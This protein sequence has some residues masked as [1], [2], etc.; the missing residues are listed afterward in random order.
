ELPV[1]KD[2][3]FGLASITKS[4]VCL[5]VMQLRDAGKLNVDD[6]VVSWLPSLKLPNEN[7]NNQIQIHEL[8]S[9]T[10]G[11]HGLPL[12]HNARLES[13][14][15]DPDSAYL[16][17]K[18]LPEDTP[19]IH[20]VDDLIR[21]INEL[22]F[23]LLGPPGTIFNYSNEGYALLQKIIELASGMS[24]IDYVEENIFAP[25][26]INDAYFRMEDIPSNAQLTEL[27]AYTEDRQNVFHSP[28]W[29]DVGAIYTNGSLKCSAAD[30]MKYAEVY[31]MDGTVNGV[32]IVSKTSIAEMTT[33][34]I[35]EPNGGSYG[36]GIGM[37]VY[38]NIAYF[39]HGGSIKGVSSNFQVIK[40]Q[41]ITV[42]VL[43]SMADVPVDRILLH[44][45]M[46][47]LDIPEEK[48][49]YE[50]YPYSVKSLQKFVGSY[51]SLEGLEATV[52]LKEEN[53]V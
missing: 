6:N 26:Q 19:V 11:L 10:S 35:S 38:Q 25:L 17:N 47:L 5:A 16:F 2:T 27:Y 8:M 4:L 53:L 44:C 30:L 3:I 39:G 23:K 43:V 22:D 13:I 40:E 32:Q 28:T 37:D 14:H 46:A 7:Y 48:Q 29:W 33:P 52:M 20:N 34:K 9:H 12:V 45:L 18:K 31:R 42:S 36:Y 50:A 41:G 15:Q 49:T 21:E 51:A 1:T 24:F